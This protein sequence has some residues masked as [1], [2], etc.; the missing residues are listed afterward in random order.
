MSW[1]E[2]ENG[3]LLMCSEC[4]HMTDIRQEDK[5]MIHPAKFNFCPHCGKSMKK[6]ADAMTIDDA[7]YCMG[8]HILSGK[9]RYGDC[10]S[11]KHYDSCKCNEAHKM[12][13]RSLKSW[14]ALH[15]R[16]ERAKQQNKEHMELEITDFDEGADIALTSI[17]VIVNEFIKEIEEG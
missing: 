2:C 10:V 4:G 9:E 11:C 12:A 5:A 3:N 13:I 6:K 15:D 8:T 16:V 1:I 17:Q 14:K 7:I